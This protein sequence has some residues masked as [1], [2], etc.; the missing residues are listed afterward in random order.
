MS[1]QTEHRAEAERAED[2]YAHRDDD[3][4]WG[5]PV[6][7]QGPAQLNVMVSVRFSRAEADHLSAVA[8]AAGMSRSALVRQAALSST[9]GKVL[10]LA[11]VRQNMDEAERRLTAA[12]QALG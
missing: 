3:D 11:R 9:T 2:H 4:R 8:E 10:D 5:D 12:R 6:P 1:E 7:A